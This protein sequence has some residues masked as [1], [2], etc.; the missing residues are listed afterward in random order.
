MPVTPTYPG[1]YVQEEKSGVRTITGVATS[2]TAFVGR[3]KRGPVNDP[4]TINSYAD[5]ER[6]FGG[7]WNEST[8]GY[9]VRDFYRN[10]GSQAVVV[11]LFSPYFASEE[12][13]GKALAAATAVSDAAKAAY[14]KAF[15]AA[16]AVSD[17]A[18]GG[19]DL[20]AS[21]T[22][23]DDAYDD[24]NEATTNTAAEKLAAKTANDLIQA[25][26]VKADLDEVAGECLG[27]IAAAASKTAADDAYDVINTAVPAKS[28]AEKL[29]AKTANDT[30]QAVAATGT[31][32][33][34]INNAADAGVLLAVP[35]AKAR[36]TVGTLTLEAAS[37]GAWGSSLKATV[38]SDTR[39]PTDTKLFNL[40]VEDG[41][42]N[43]EQFL[44][45]SSDPV[46]PR[47]LP[48]VL[49]QQSELVRVQ[50]TGITW[51][52]G[53][54]RPAGLPATASGIGGDDGSELKSAAF[55]GENTERDKLG[56]YSLEKVDLFNL[57][58]IPP[59]LAT[60][61]IDT[62]VLTDAVTYCEKR[63]AFLIVDPPSTWVS[64]KGVL[65]NRGTLV[66]GSKNAAIYFPRVKSPDPLNDNRLGEFA[67]C[68]VVAGIYARTDSERGVWKA[69]AGLEARASGVTELT[70]KLTDLENGE[71]NQWGINC[72]RVM[73][74]GI[75]V[76]G[77]RT[78]DGADR[79]ASEWKY[80]PVRR[81]ALFIEE[82]LYRG[83][84]WVVFEP[85]DEP[86]WSQIRLNAGAFMHNLFRQG[87][88]QGMS[89]K[90]AYFVKCDKETTTQNDI[91]LGIVNIWVG[92]APLKPAEFVIIHLQQMAGQVKV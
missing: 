44:N 7:L 52:I 63:R 78:L 35:A 60:G 17:A 32:M 2:I 18:L 25:C 24:I 69:P 37:E 54:E 62:A 47:F 89:P 30:I 70:Y 81:T 49:Q 29:A 43:R 23:A 27:P 68:G 46:A 58:C 77:A 15:A 10:G 83:M 65:D 14:D 19:A 13:R 12:E 8:L 3:A 53:T 66:P 45:V 85:N 51:T 34:E 39:N 87:A 42:G 57:L 6:T 91:N 86:L 79:I 61:D 16:K 74:E 28:A 75:L 56:L 50:K 92:F 11:R 33:V 1:V 90:D 84:K 40:T 71:L 22:A 26:T 48:R 64:K 67:P 55:N 82:S 31:T 88:F 20:D 36:L 72:L 41:S 5:F 38:D 4:I 59:Y 73:P 80:V 21:K 9:A 76:W